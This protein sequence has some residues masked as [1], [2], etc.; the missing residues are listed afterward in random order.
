MT[1]RNLDAMFR[2]ASL[3]L[4]GASQK[5]GT[6]GNVLARNL[7]NGGFKGDIFLVNPK[8]KTIEG[9]P[10]Y[11]AIDGL[12]RIPDLAVL[13]TPPD[14]VPALIESLGR[15]GTRAAVVITAGFGEGGRDKGLAL[16]ERMLAAA[17]PHLLR[18][19]GP[20][21]LGLMVPGVGLNA[22]FGQV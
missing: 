1:I 20:N 14:T 12:P 10:A 17:R 6:I 19:V 16:C 22:S 2:P 13:A 21:C 7:L 11:P 18:I 9:Q 4:V 8:Y 15:Q 3:A 5:T